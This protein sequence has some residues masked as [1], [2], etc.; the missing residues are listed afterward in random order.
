MIIVCEKCNIIYG[1]INVREPGG[2]IQKGHDRK[3]HLKKKGKENN[4]L[5]IRKAKIGKFGGVLVRWRTATTL[6]AANF[7]LL[8]QAM[9][10]QSVRL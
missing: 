6:V 10:L 3:N 2:E 4:D 5:M 1:W 7:I 9:A 8:A